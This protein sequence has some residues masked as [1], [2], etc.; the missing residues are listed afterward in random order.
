MT[1]CRSLWPVLILVALGCQSGQLTGE[2]T[3]GDCCDGLDNDRDGMLDE[4]DP[5][6][7]TFN[8]P[9]ICDVASDGV[10]GVDAAT[11]TATDASM[12]PIE[13]DDPPVSMEMPDAGKPA[14]L[15]PVTLDAGPRCATGE[16]GTV[17]ECIDGFC[18]PLLPAEY[19]MTSLSADAP[20]SLN[21]PGSCLDTCIIWIGKA[22]FTLC[23]C[24]ADPFVVIFLD[25]GELGRTEALVN[26]DVGSWTLSIP[27]TADQGSQL[28]FDVY[29]AESDGNDVLLYSCTVTLDA[30]ILSQGRLECAQLFPT[31]SG[32]MPFGVRTVVRLVGSVI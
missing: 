9:V 1:R 20:R 21:Y 27:F 19:E 14:V 22:P 13:V 2:L 15:P 32:D 5:D 16:C 31:E 28:R 18:I 6:C 8:T 23:G 7:W 10:D 24:E 4:A 12:P 26:Q 25:G 3:I 17:A 30:G 29:D 11:A